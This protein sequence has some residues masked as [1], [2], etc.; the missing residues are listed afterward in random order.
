MNKDIEFGQYKKHY[1]IVQLID[2]LTLYNMF[3]TNNK[4][5]SIM[6][7]KG[8]ILTLLPLSA[9]YKVKYIFAHDKK[10]KIIEKDSTQYKKLLLR[11][12]GW[13]EEFEYELSGYL[14]EDNVHC[15]GI[16]LTKLIKQNL[17]YD[18]SKKKLIIKTRKDEIRITKI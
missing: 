10:L 18:D 13:E 7:K 3:K 6:D 1:Y 2:D 12:S 8:H 9:K 14:Y 16:D 5:L 17:L 11:L 4:L 15:L